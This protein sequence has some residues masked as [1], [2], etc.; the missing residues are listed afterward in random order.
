[1]SSGSPALTEQEMKRAS[2]DAFN[3]GLRC[4]KAKEWGAG[5]A[6]FTVAI[7]SNH[8]RLGMPSAACL[9]SAPASFYTAPSSPLLLHCVSLASLSSSDRLGSRVR[10]GACYNLRGESRAQLGDLVGAF[11]DLDRSVELMPAPGERGWGAPGNIATFVNRSNCYKKVGRYAAATADLRQALKLDPKHRQAKKALGNCILLMSFRA[12]T[13]L[14]S[15]IGP[16]SSNI[17]CATASAAE[18][19][20]AMAHTEGV[21]ATEH[22]NAAGKSVGSTAKADSAD[23][24]DKC[25]YSNALNDM[26]DSVAASSVS[27]DH[28][29]RRSHTVQNIQ[30]GSS[31]M[32]RSA[33]SDSIMSGS[34]ISPNHHKAADP[35]SE[36]G[37]A[38]GE[39]KAA[40]QEGEDK[41]YALVAVLGGRTG[42]GKTEILHRLR[43]A[44]Q[45]VVDLEGLACHR[46]SAFGAIGQEPQPTNEMYENRCALAWWTQSARALHCHD[47]FVDGVRKYS[48]RVWMEHEGPHVGK[49]KV[50]EGLVAQLNAAKGGFVVVEMDRALRVERLVEDYCSDAQPTSHA[51]GGC[52]Q[53]TLTATAVATAAAAAAAVASPI[54]ARALNGVG[55]LGRGVAFASL[56]FGA[57][58]L[59]RACVTVD[60]MGLQRHRSRQ[61]DVQ[62]RGCIEN[63]RRKLG[64]KKYNEASAWLT[65]RDYTNLA[66][67][68]LDYYDGLYDHHRQTNTSQL[69]TESPLATRHDYSLRYT[70]DAS[71]TSLWPLVVPLPL[72]TQAR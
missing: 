27:A 12:A 61:I 42:S 22:A 49:C 46:G 21:S 3:A 25:G 5:A 68:M 59:H 70:C 57:F 72:G 41:K 67:M 24:G 1:V 66:D 14:H 29:K 17:A 71:L 53:A 39:D 23:D 28:T 48:G 55:R 20:L 2:V 32:H 38:E 65:M 26:A 56:S 6:H 13:L 16:S 34:P 18:L 30:H 19:E 35:E 7:D 15:R 47:C 40:V 64:E 4:F 9:R 36:S 62:L 44:G 11:Q 51:A 37:F 10:T 60:P 45:A 31:G 8:P 52:S 54:S 43:D 58:A 33:S 63:L 69:R 50:P